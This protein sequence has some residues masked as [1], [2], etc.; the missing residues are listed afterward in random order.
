MVRY[1]VRN[2][3]KDGKLVA[4]VGDL[5]A[6]PFDDASF[7]ITITTGVLEYLDARTAIGEISRVTRP[8]GMVVAS[9][10]NP[11]SPYRLTQ[12]FLYWPALRAAGAIERMLGVRAGG[13]APRAPA[14]ALSGR[15][16]SPH[17]CAKRDSPTSG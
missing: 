14:S 2:A 1:C 13:T 15:P 17:T 12:W 6:L 10:L 16:A 5:E 7:D 3:D 9:M 11:L 8:G 4:S